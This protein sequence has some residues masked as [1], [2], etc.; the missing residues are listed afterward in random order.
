MDWLLKRF[1]NSLGKWVGGSCESTTYSGFDMG[2]MRNRTT[3]WLI[4]RTAYG[5]SIL[6]GTIHQVGWKRKIG[7]HK[8]EIC[9]GFR[10]SRSG[11]CHVGRVLL[12]VMSMFP[13]L[14]DDF[15]CI[16]L[17]IHHCF[18]RAR[19]FTQVPIMFS[20]RA[21]ELI[22]TSSARIGNFRVT[23]SSLSKDKP[24]RPLIRINRCGIRSPCF[25][26]NDEILDLVMCG[27][28]PISSEGKPGIWLRNAV[29]IEYENLVF[30]GGSYQQ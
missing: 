24:W 29:D 2:V 25:L 11:C 27:W 4:W 17:F 10:E 19:G 15:I 18:H 1:T 20:N 9:K 26:L 7:R 5:S 16:K 12:H 8:W 22:I 14:F 13:Q 6:T 21:N 3:Y 30:G 28:F 23:P